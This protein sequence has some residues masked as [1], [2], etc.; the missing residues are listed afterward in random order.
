MKI[1]QTEMLTKIY[2]IEKKEMRGLA[3]FLHYG[4]K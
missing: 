3:K 2:Q 1:T 4:I